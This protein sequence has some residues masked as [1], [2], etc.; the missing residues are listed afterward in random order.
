MCVGVR[1]CPGQGC[2]AEADNVSEAHSLWSPDLA[3]STVHKHSCISDI[4]VQEWDYY[5]AEQFQVL[6]EA[7]DHMEWK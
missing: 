7:G 4:V 3:F 6:L 2:G 1:G 5:H